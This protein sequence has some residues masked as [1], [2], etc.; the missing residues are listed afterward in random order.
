M[1]HAATLLIC[2]ASLAGGCSKPENAPAG[3]ATG[4]ATAAASGCP[5]GAY[6][7]DA[8]AFCVP[9]PKGYA[10]EPQG[11]DEVWF[12]TEGAKGPVKVR[13]TVYSHAQYVNEVKGMKGSGFEVEEKA[14]GNG[15]M[16]TATHPVGKNT[17]VN[18]VLK[19]AKPKD[20]PE[21]EDQLVTCEASSWPERPQPEALDACKAMKLM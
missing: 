11:E 12:T 2:C 6:K 18:V 20:A 4:S 5:D 15:T 14:L 1:K 21:G 19:G 13:W 7:H 17:I 9:I 3:A 8:P 16:L 10:V